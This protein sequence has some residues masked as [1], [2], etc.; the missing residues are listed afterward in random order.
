MTLEQELAD[1]KE[2]KKMLDRTLI[3]QRRSLKERHQVLLEH[4]RVLKRRQG[5][6]DF[7]FESEIQDIDLAPIKQGLIEQQQQLQQQQQQLGQELARIEQSIQELKADLEGKVQA[8]KR[9]G[10]AD[11]ATTR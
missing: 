2:A 3:G 8:K 9:V 11:Y 1:E 10:I 6:I 7:D 5:V 4:S